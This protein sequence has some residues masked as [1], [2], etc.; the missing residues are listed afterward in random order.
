MQREYV[1]FLRSS[2]EF[3]PNI[4]TRTKKA[5]KKVAKKMGIKPKEITYVGIHNRKTD[6]IEFI[7]ENFD[8]DPIDTEY[9]YDAMDYFR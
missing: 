7:K 8:Q 5:F 9:F 2:L 1:K 4:V 3:R 6:S